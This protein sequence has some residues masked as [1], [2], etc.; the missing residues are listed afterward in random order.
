MS[1]RFEPEYPSTYESIRCRSFDVLIDRILALS[2]I[3]P[4]GINFVVNSKTIVDLD[5]AVQLANE[6]GA[7]EFLLLPEEPVG[8]GF[9]ID[10]ETE[11]RLTEWVYKYRGSV[12]LTV[13]ESRSEGLPVCCPLKAES[14]LSAYAHIDAE[15]VLKRT[16]YDSF[17]VSICDNELIPALNQ[18]KTTIQEE[19][20]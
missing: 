16:S 15:G 19:E 1:D 13:S 8:S 10:N 20:I 17:G 11:N 3:A 12:P 18:L 6:L 2:S 4:F 9:G 14:G 7:L 5:E